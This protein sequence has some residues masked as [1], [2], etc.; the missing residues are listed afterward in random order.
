M[1]AN[2]ANDLNN[3]WS[4]AKVGSSASALYVI[5]QYILQN[6]LLLNLNSMMENL[7]GVEQVEESVNGGEVEDLTNRIMNLE[8]IYIGGGGFGDVYKTD[9]AHSDRTSQPVV[10]KIL[11]CFQTDLENPEKRARLDKV[12]TCTFPGFDKAN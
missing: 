12:R 9:L 6:V 7:H 3:G 2:Y 5:I 4:T 1:I 11:R 10:V 8:V